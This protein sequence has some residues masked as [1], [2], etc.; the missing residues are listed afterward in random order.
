MG[1]ITCF[2]EIDAWKESRMLTQAIY[3]VTCQGNFARDWGLVRQLQE[4][5]VSVMSN[6][7]EGFDGGSK[8]EFVRFLGYARRSASEVQSHLYVALDQNYIA[9]H[10]F[11]TLYQRAQTVRKMVTAFIKYLRTQQVNQRGN[12]RT[13]EPANPIAWQLALALNWLRW[14]CAP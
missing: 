3:R 7:A 5:S 8:A 6:I 9:T 14:H 2:E 11:T 4:S 1:N 12:P 10:E 13:R